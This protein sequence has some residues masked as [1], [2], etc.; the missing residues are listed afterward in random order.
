MYLITY[1]SP[2]KQYTYRIRYQSVTFDQTTLQCYVMWCALIRT[3]HAQTVSEIVMHFHTH[4]KPLVYWKTDL[5]VEHVLLAHLLLL[6]FEGRAW[7]VPLCVVRD[8]GEG[9]STFLVRS[10]HL[11]SCRLHWSSF[12]LLNVASNNLEMVIRWI[13]MIILS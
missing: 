1:D 11:F 13:T 4:T 12:A 9:T 5:L 8:V 6:A 2:H 3:Q 7:R 10:A